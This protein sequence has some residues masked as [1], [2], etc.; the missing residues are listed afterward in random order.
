MVT[1]EK[2]RVPYNGVLMLVVVC[3]APSRIGSKIG[4]LVGYAFIANLCFLLGPFIDGYLTWLGLRH[5]AVTVFVFLAGTLV[6]VVLAAL[7]VS[8]W[9]VG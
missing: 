4:E 2:L 3:L 6:A 8:V 7:C 5:P 1:W 9:G